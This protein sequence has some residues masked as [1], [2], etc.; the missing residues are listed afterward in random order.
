MLKKTIHLLSQ[1]R[2]LIEKINFWIALVLV[3]S[4]PFYKQ[5]IPKIIFLWILTWLL[6]GNFKQK[7]SSGKNKILLFIIVFFYL[8]HILGLLYSANLKSSFFDLEVKLSLLIIPILLYASNNLYYEKRNL[9]L[10]SF[11]FGN[12]IA[13]I[14]CVMIV[15][16][17]RMFYNN[18]YDFQYQSLS[19]FMHPS[20]FAMYLVFSIIIIANFIFKK[21]STKK[22]IIVINYFMI[23]FF[24]YIIFLLSSRSGI[25]SGFVTITTFSLI[26]LTK[27]VNTFYK[28]SFVLIA[29]LFI[30]L[31]FKYNGRV[32]Y[33]IKQLK[34]TSLNSGNQSIKTSNDR[35]LIWMSTLKIIKNNFWIGVGNGDV[36]E[37]L[38]VVYK[39]KGL[40]EAI[41]SKLNVHNQFI[42]TFVA[43]GII[44]FVLLVLIFLI[45]FIIAIKEKN[46]ILLLFIITIG[47]NF[48]FESMLNTQAGVVFFTFFYSY[49]LFADSKV[50]YNHTPDLEQSQ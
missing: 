7:F 44:G 25:I 48:L 39:D 11:V 27:K 37:E 35:L 14:I 2:P 24:L 30:F 47:I 12:F 3:F 26:F 33:G 45:P 18:N 10:Y 42:E 32:N 1:Y 8:F 5:I 31:T 22:I 6:E 36:K 29:V 13:A 34:E 50:Q 9:I 23:L 17:N 38:T 49:L 15:I 21:T 41:T 19:F 16:V 4:M 20:Y 28:I 43:Q 46:N 40:D